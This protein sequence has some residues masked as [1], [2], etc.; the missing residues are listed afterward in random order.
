MAPTA[1]PS[2]VPGGLF[3]ALRHRNYAL[4]WSGALVSNTGTWLGNLTVPYVL[5]QSTGSAIWVGIATAAQFGPALLLSPVG[6]LLADGVD[7]RILLAWT[8]AGLGL[9]ATL[10]WLQ[11][12]SGLHEPWLLIALLTLFGMLNGINN[13]AWQSLVNDLVPRG[14]ILSAVTLNSLQFNLARAIGPAIAGVLLSGLGATWAFFLNAASFVVVVVTL[15]FVRTA[16]KV[17]AR[18]AGSGFRAQWAEALG[19]LRAHRVLL[20]AVLLCCLVGFAA[21]PIFSLTVVFA[22][23]VYGTSARGLGLLTAALGAGAVLFAL[24]GLLPARR[25]ASFGRKL[26]A[27]FLVL[28]LGH[29]AYALLNDFSVGLLAG[30]AIGAAFLG[31]MSTLNS[32]IQLTAPDRLR[33]RIMAVRHMVFSSSVALGSFLSGV[34]SDA[35]GVQSATL[36]LGVLLL[37]LAA[38][39]GCSRTLRGWLDGTQLA[40][41]EGIAR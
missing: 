35:W 21:N 40:D 10:M 19:Y 36:L 32:I 12:A 6:G 28:G 34:M 25:P 29:A 8:Q 13:P 37:A 2:E 22:E 1:P 17:P 26:V 27:S 11:W 24:A 38:G 31:A 39:L 4:F 18:A 33:G 5:Y 15:L 20:L 7:R 23:S 30:V 14:D 9:V 3:S 16:R 41:P